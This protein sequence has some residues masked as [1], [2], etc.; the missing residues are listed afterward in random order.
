[1]TDVD[2]EGWGAGGVSPCA[3]EAGE[4]DDTY[5]RYSNYGRDIDIVAP[6]TCVES[7]RPTVS[8]NDTAR[9]SGTSMA[10]PHV[11][12]AVARYLADHPGTPPDRMRRIVRAAGRM[13]WNPKSDPLW[14]GVERP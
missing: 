7:T 4:R 11:T 13:D 5:A 14:Y 9:S 10:A 6:G 1:M 8:G 2:G 3:G 12:G